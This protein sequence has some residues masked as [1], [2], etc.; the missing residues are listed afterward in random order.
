LPEQ[1]PPDPDLGA[2]LLGKLEPGERARFEQRLAD[3][4]DL[5][6]AAEELEGTV[7][8]LGHAAPAFEVPAG[9]EARTFRAPRAG[10]RGIGPDG[11]ARATAVAAPLALRPPRRRRCS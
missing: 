4:P 11:R 8:L 2:Y 10:D 1:T 7:E 3:D 9:L 6:S 5:R